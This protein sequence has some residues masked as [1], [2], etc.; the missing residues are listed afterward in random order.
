MQ[1]KRLRLQLPLALFAVGSFS[2]SIFAFLK[3]S[4]PSAK[5]LRVSG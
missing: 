3:I 5:E 2:L 1:V 4:D